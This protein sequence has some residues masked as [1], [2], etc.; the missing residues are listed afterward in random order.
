MSELRLDAGSLLLQPSGGH[1]R[2]L[3]GATERPLSGRLS[4][5]TGAG[6]LLPGVIAQRVDCPEH[7]IARQLK[8]DHVAPPIF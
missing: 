2:V 7:A 5:L 8:S 3:L 6:D 4:F 1:C